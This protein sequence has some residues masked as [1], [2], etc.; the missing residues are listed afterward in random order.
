MYIK[1]DYSNYLKP[2]MPFEVFLIILL[3]IMVGLILEALGLISVN[4]ASIGLSSACRSQISFQIMA[5]DNCPYEVI[6]QLSIHPNSIN[7]YSSI[8]W[9]GKKK[10]TPRV[11]HLQESDRKHHGKISQ[12]ANRKMGKAIDYLLFMSRPK[13]AF[14]SMAGKW[15]NFQIAFVTLTL[16][17]P[18]FHSDNEIKEKCLNQFLV[19]ARK[20]WNV[21]NYIWRAEKQKN[22]SI[23]FHILLDRFIPWS[24]LR[25]VWNRIINKLSYVEK[26]R[27][28]MRAFHSGGFRVRENLLQSW[29]YKHQVKAYKAGKANDW[30]S[31][32]ST[33][34]HSIRK[35]NDIRSYIMKYQ[36]KEDTNGEIDG[37]IWGC[38]Q[39]L[40]NIK[41]AVEIASYEYSREI[42]FISHYFPERV[43]RSDYFSVI[44]VSVDELYKMKCFALFRLFCGFM[45]N[46]FGFSYQIST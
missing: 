5:I 25:D 35:V 26:Y 30:S 43:F 28:S 38:N 13:K 1:K 36:M 11:S 27:D 31:P 29:D 18:Q 12:Q 6:P 19:E 22:G 24:Q 16:P 37:R 23:H 33:D 8:Q 9:T 46:R 3:V 21:V 2:R 42:S 40:S 7:L 17:S 41:G 14:N 39:E 4:G 10:I 15:F 44:H 32:N 45:N 20:K 34:I